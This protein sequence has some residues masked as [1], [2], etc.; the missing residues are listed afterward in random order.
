MTASPDWIIDGF[1]SILD[2]PHDAF[3][4]E[5]DPFGQIV[6]SSY[7]G[8]DLSE[9]GYGV[10][11]DMRGNVWIIGETNS[12]DWAAGGLSETY[13]GGTWDAYVTKPYADGAPTRGSVRGAA[14]H[15]EDG[16]GDWD[17]DEPPLD[18]WTIYI[19]RDHNGQWDDGERSTT[20]GPD[21][22]YVLSQLLS[23][24][25][26]VA[27]V[28]PPDW[29]RTFPPESTHEVT[30]APGSVATDRDFGARLPPEVQGRYV[31]YNASAFDGNDA[32]ADARDDDAI[33]TD[34][35]ALLP[36]KAA[37]F[38]NYTSYTGG[39]NGVMIDVANLLEGV[40][41][42][43]S[44]FVFRIGDDST[45]DDWETV[46]TPA[47]VTFREHAG[48]GGSDRVTIT[49][50][51][52]TVRNQWLE[53]TVLAADLGMTADDV[54]YFG[55]AVAEVGDSPSG[56]QVTAADLLVARNNPRDFLRP[57]PVDFICDFNRDSFVDAIDLLLARNN[58][59]DFLTGVQLID[60]SGANTAGEEAAPLRPAETVW[61]YDLQWPDPQ[62][63]APVAEDVAPWAVD[64]LL[65]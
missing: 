42:T 19:D 60:L 51:E 39:I 38:E 6:Q 58:Q 28:L 3:F 17:A 52:G 16:D 20:T 11:A 48:V 64:L 57:A 14:F 50:P 43:A 32:V 4:T 10:A 40:V 22:T 24:V 2:G 59:T 9:W 37:S 1:D 5:L 35:V 34:K 26:V 25:H 12:V 45:P 53:V 8:G 29:L 54:F 44:D 36:G 30:L 15:D 13:H 49:W 27:Q 33:A 41:P 31:F 61:L 7:V 55:N 63:R 56:A 18:D 65:A 47:T 62:R 46:S 21:G 23:G